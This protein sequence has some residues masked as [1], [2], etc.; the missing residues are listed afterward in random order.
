MRPASPADALREVF[1]GE[2]LV[3]GHPGYDEARHVFNGMI[4]RH[5]AVIAR[6]ATTAD[7]V[8]AVEVARE[9]D[10][11]VAVRG[12]GHS[13]SGLSTCD[14]G[15]VFDLSGLKSIE[16]DSQTRAAKAGGGTLWG[17]FDAATQ[18]HALHTPGGRVTITGIAGFTL[19][20]V[21][22]SW[23]H[24]AFLAAVTIVAI[25]STAS[26]ALIERVHAIRRERTGNPV[27]CP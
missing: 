21:W 9:S 11:L 2:V 23:T 1:A 10:L 16:V 7:V 26:A 13:F 14:E 6:C 24:L 12:G 19:G 17:E 4:D 25:V 20:G 27:V 8:K 18:A 5:P 3:P 22:G 15:I